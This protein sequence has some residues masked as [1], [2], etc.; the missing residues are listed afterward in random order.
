MPKTDVVVKL[1][2]ENGNIYSLLGTVSKALKKAGYREEAEEMTTKVFA[3]ASY[4]KALNIF[5]E[6]VEVT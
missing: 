2:G 3:C 1:T 6:Y 4:N 5:Q